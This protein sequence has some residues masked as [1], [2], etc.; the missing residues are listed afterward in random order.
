MPD[1]I[2]A[3]NDPLYDLAEEGDSII[4]VIPIDKEAPKGRLILPQVQTIRDIL[5]NECISVVTQP[6]HT[7][8]THTHTHACMHHAQTVTTNN[9]PEAVIR[10]LG[11]KP[12][13]IELFSAWGL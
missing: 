8:H 11:T 4:L 6:H 1:E 13:I 7:T 3:P 5:D 2:I 9:R 10:N 12:R